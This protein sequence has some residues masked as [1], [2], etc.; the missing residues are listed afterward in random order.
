MKFGELIEYNMRNLFLEKSS[1][2]YDGET[3]PESFSGK[4]KLS[5]SLDQHSNVLHSLFLFY[6]KLRAI[7]KKEAKLQITCFYLILS[8]FKK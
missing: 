8:I 2:N 4:L 1:T 7:E 3:S 5:I 6:P